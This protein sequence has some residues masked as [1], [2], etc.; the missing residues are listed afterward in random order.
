MENE[1]FERMPVPKAYMK[2]AVPVMM[3]TVLML[4][5]NMVDMYFI[6]KTGNTNLVAGVSLCAPIFTFMV[7]IGDIFGLGG[8]S[9]IS[10]L[11]GRGKVDDGRRLSVF[12]FLGSALFGV[13][14]AVLF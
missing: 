6:A 3:S 12:S 9:V 13:V 11:F 10:R 2:L 8:S 1:L 4:V 5:Y 14:I 7:A